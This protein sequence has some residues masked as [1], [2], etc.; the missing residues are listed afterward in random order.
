MTMNDAQLLRYSRQIML[1]QIDIAGQ[2]KLLAATVFVAGLGGLGSPVSL[3][4]AAAGVGQLRLADHDTVDVTNLQ[5]QILHTRHS[6]GRAKTASAA[7]ALN[8]LNDDTG[9]TLIEDRLDATTLP[10]ALAGADLVIDAT[11]NFTIRYALNDQC[12]AAG[13]PLVSGAAI[14]FEGQVAVFD[15]R[16]ADAP[17][18]RCLYPKGSDMP[19]NCAENGVAAPLVGVIGSVQ[20]MEAM[21]LLTGAGTALTGHV[22]YYDALAG[23]WH[24]L[25]LRRSPNCPLHTAADQA[26]S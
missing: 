16:V 13:I 19:L 11:D 23:D 12:F 2:E 7:A 26:D 17:C 14:G 21:K 22:L 6:I 8:A 9:V 24:R 15:P 20:A 3:Y 10:D 25:R 5:R 4:L 1:P 18:Y